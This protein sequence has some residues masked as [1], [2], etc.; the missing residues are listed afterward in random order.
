MPI[1]FSHVLLFAVLWTVARQAPLST[2]FSRQE[3]CNGFPFPSPGDLPYQGIDPRSPVLQAD[4]LTS[5]LPGKVPRILYISG[6][7]KFVKL[8]AWHHLS[9]N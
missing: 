3:Y 8:K 7:L 1:H 2:G 5:E 6:R 9:M 4:A